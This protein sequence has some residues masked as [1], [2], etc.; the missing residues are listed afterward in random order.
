MVTALPTVTVGL[1]GDS[2]IRV[3]V[4]GSRG[5]LAVGPRRV[6]P[7]CVAALQHPDVVL[8]MLRRQLEAERPLAEFGQ[9]LLVATGASARHLSGPTGQNRL[10]SEI[11]RLVDGAGG[12]LPLEDLK[13]SARWRGALERLERSGQLRR[14]A[15]TPTD[16]C[17]VLGLIDVGTGARAAREPDSLEHGEQ[18]RTAPWDAAAARAGAELFSRQ[19]DRYGVDV[20][21]GA[22]DLSRQVLRVALRSATEALL[23]VAVGADGTS[24]RRNPGG[25]SHRRP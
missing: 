18:Q 25:S 15:L 12:A 23:S 5:E 13:R 20:G 4:D 19:R 2:E 22:T 1:G 3:P 11:M 8:P 9:V 17:I 21:A 14:S 10:D 6:V 7:L 24:P 16:A